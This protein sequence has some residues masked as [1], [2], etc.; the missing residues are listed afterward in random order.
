M[1]DLFQYNFLHNFLYLAKTEM[2]EVVKLD[3][4]L[5]N[6]FKSKLVFIYSSLDG[7]VPIKYIEE[8]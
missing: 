5:I 8:I 2:Q 1:D 4:E 3:E 6:N 7:W